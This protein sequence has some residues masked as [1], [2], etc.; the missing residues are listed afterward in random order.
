[1]NKTLPLLLLMLLPALSFAQKKDKKKKLKPDV[2][3]TT[4]FG[5]IGIIL[6]EDMPEH[7]NN[8]LKL[9]SEGFYDGTTF[10]RVMK[11]F[12]IQGGDPNSKSAETMARAGQGGPGY[13]LEADIRPDKFH[14]KGMLAAARQPDQVNPDRRS[15]GSQ[16][17]IVQ[18]RTFNDK[19]LAGMERQI[20]MSQ[21]QGF[22][23]TDAQKEIYKTKGGT[24]WLDMGYTIYGEVI[25]GLE[26]VDQIALVETNRGNR[27]LKDIKMTMEV[28][29][30]FKKAK[31]KKKKKKKNKKK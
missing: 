11:D 9:A 30:K 16:F 14:T 28:K 17:Y 29:A 6:Y 19:E 21:P 4:D 15:S 31:K 7:R 25:Y 3:I 22:K 13:T 8:F 2:I 20:S 26:V 18:G 5:T 27:P 23:Y 24:P 1:M 12:M 10:H